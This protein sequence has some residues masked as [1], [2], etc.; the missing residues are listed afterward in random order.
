MN[1]S[2]KVIILREKVYYV[3]VLEK[4]K[5]LG[6][7]PLVED[8]FEA[9]QVNY[10]ILTL[11]IISFL[12]KNKKVFRNFT[13][14]TFEKILILSVDEVFKKNNVQVNEEDLELILGLLQNSFLIKQ[15]S[16]FIKDLCL[17]MYYSVKK[18]CKSC[19][20]EDSVQ[21]VEPVVRVVE[22]GQIEGRV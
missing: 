8:L 21:V 6:L 1:V 3:K 16:L 5:L 7:I 19:K 2:S 15:I 18:N 11:R 17:K 13:Q 22:V 9:N 20:N 12:K 14:D 10:A 4:L